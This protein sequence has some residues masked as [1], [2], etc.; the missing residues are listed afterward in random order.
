MITSLLHDGAPPGEPPYTLTQAQTILR[1]MVLDSMQSIHPKR[2]YAKA[3]DDLALND[4]YYS[5]GGSSGSC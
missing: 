5:E 3:L 4:I 1:Q 2:N